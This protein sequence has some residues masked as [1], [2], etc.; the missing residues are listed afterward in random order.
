MQSEAGDLLS[1]TLYITLPLSP[2]FSAL[3]PLKTISGLN[4]LLTLAEKLILS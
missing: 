4:T 3:E 1:L 2:K